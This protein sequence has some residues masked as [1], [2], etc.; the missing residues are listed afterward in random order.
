MMIKELIHYENITILNVYAPYN[1]ISKHK[2]QKFKELQG[3]INKSTIIVKDF[4]T[5]S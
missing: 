3:K 5:F 2:E 4:S 1:K